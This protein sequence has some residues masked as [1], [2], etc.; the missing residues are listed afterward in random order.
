M[1]SAL[2]VQPQAPPNEPPRATHT[3]PLPLPAQSALEVQ[4]HVLDVALQAPPLG[5]LVQSA[6]VTQPTHRP[7]V[8]LQTGPTPALPGQSALEAHARMHTPLE[9][10][11]GI[12][13]VHAR[14]AGQSALDEQPH[15]GPQ[16]V[17]LSHT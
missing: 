16:P 11:P 7:V 10:T 15:A 8:V 17:P 3:E 13:V 2:V 12:P 5:F 6:L 9:P 14:P 1:Q 4:P